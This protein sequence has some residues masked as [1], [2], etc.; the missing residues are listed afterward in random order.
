MEVRVRT[1]GL[2]ME[3]VHKGRV[4]WAS[5]NQIIAHRSTKS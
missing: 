1:T 4:S 2:A 3:M 5:L